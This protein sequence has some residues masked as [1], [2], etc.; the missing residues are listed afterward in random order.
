MKKLILLLLLVCTCATLSWAQSG[1]RITVTGSVIDGDDKSPVGQA[2]VQLLS[3]PDS[4]M[5]VGNVTNNNGV[6]SIAA[7]PGK[8]VLKISFVGYLTQEKSLQLTAGK[9]SV[10]IGTVTLPTDAIMLGE[11]VIVAEAPQVTIS[12]DTIGYNASAYRTP[13]GA[14]LEELVKKLP[15]AEIDD[16]GN[17]KINGKEVKKIMVDG[18]EFFGG[19]VKTGLKNLPVDMVEKLKTYDTYRIDGLTAGIKYDTRA[20]LMSNIDKPFPEFFYSRHSMRQFESKSINIEDVE[21]AIKI[22]QKAPTACNRQASKVYLYKDKATNDA[23]GEL[24]AGNTGFQQEV[25][26]YLVV[27]ADVSAFYDTFERNQVYVE[28]GLFSMALVE[29]LHYYGIGSCILQNGE[30]YKKNKKFKEICKNI[31]ENERIILFVA[32]GYYKNKFSYAMSLRKNVED[33][34]IVK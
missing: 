29:A 25:P 24:I 20:N 3:L 8:Y 28:A 12:E 27:T 33:V 14:M 31:P 16:D 10:N 15:G 21:K 18:K 9:P 32:T 34:F 7:R 6:F 4:T 23:L 5:V 19:D 2:T 17:I 1:K 13:E 26:N 11:A 22:A 30:Y